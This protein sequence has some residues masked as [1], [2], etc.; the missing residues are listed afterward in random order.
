[1]KRLFKFKYPKLFLLAA[2]SIL[3]FYL[4]S[5]SVVQ[6]Y[7]EELNSFSYVGIF[8]AGLF[9][10]FG[11][12][13]PL[14][15]GF[16]LVAKPDNLLYATLIGASGAMLMDLFIFKIIRFSFMEEFRRLE[17]TK[18]IKE[19]SHFFSHHII[20]KIKIYLLYFFA[21]VIIA[22]PLP[23][24]LGVS[25]LAGLTAIKTRSLGIISFFMNSAGIFTMLVLGSLF[26]NWI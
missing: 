18:I 4:F 7:I 20:G 6:N 21:G 9:F 24:E 22:S 10:S 5:W 17:R 1:M 26:S 14:A 2:I 25:M 13:T 3:S 12:S 11:F 19:M 15:I 23:D 8:I 16:F